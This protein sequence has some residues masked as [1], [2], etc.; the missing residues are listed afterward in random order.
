MDVTIA[1]QLLHVGDSY[2]EEFLRYLESNTLK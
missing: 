2:R 1:G